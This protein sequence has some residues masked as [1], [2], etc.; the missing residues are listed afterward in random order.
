MHDESERLYSDPYAK[1]MYTGSFVMEWMGVS[2]SQQLFDVFFPG[3][4]ELLTLRTK[5]IDE[6]IAIHATHGA[7]DGIGNDGNSDCGQLVILGAGYDTR[8]FRMNDF[9]EG[10]KII[11]VDQPSVQASKRR[12]LKEIAERDN[13]VASRLKDNTVTFVPIDFDHHGDSIGEA[14]HSFLEGDQRTIVVLEGVTQYIPKSSTA[15]TLKQL[16]NLLP[17][18][19]VLLVSYVPQVI[20]DDPGQISSPDLIRF[21]LKG[22]EWSGEP[23]ISAWTESGFAEFLSSDQCGGYEVLSDSAVEELEKQYLVP[24]RKNRRRSLNPIPPLERYVVA[25]VVSEQ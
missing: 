11:E 6:Q 17:K 12:V 24:M 21:L 22:A 4:L 14:L 8:G 7:N 5:W 2:R 18:G 19:S 15:S 10:F 9:P 16:H 1:Y 20:F 3:L 13:L 23:W 25:R